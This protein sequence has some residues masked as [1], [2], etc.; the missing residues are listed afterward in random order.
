MTDVKDLDT[1]FSL[2][3]VQVRNRFAMAPM[4]RKHSPGGVPGPD[5][6]E[7]YRKRAAG[8]VGLIIT[9]GVYIPDPATGPDTDVPRLYDLD[10]LGGWRAVVDRVHAAGG[11]IIPQLWHLGSARGKAP[12]YN[13]DVETVSASGVATNGEPVGRAMTEADLDA[14]REAYVRA[15]LSARRSAFDGIELHGAHG[16]L[17]DGFLWDRTNQ[18]TDLFGGSHKERA[19]YPASVV[20]AVRAQVG[21]DFPIVF[22]YSQW[23]DA[24]FDA[25]IAENPSELEAVLSPLVEAGLTALHPSVRRYWEPAFP[26]LPGADGEL[27]LAGWTKR[28]TGLP[29][30]TVGSVG[31][32]APFVSRTPSREPAGF[33]GVDALL[34]QFGAGEWDIVALGRTLLSDPDWVRKLL[35]GRTDEIVPYERKHMRELV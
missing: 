31:L 5:V 13:P 8:G 3:P 29:V 28:I 32:S 26:D 20:A 2:G 10:P 24:D 33:A 23:K 4:T 12:E 18:R 15:A 6:V 25:R 30:I 35:D 14:T 7:Y 11:V 22:R 9:E 19:A 34:E 1:P 21:P 27:S 17:L 16:Y